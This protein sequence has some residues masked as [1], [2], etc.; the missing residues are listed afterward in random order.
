[1]F[2]RVALAS[3]LFAAGCAAGNVLDQPFGPDGATIRQT[4]A[5]FPK[6]HQAA[7]ALAERR[8]TPCHTLNEPFSS[9]VPPGA[10]MSVVRKM[11]RQPGA[12]IPEADRQPIADFFE[13]FFKRRAERPK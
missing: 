7:F 12:L 11:A 4:I 2:R 8:C 10:W 6:E 5:T 13:Y 3:F 1:M 9:H